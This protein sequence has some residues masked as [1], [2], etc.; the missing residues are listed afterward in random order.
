MCRLH[1]H[2]NASQQVLT[3]NA[4]LYVI[5][6]MLDAERKQLQHQSQQLYCVVIL[7]GRFVVYGIFQERCCEREGSLSLIL[8][9]RE[10]TNKNMNG[11]LVEKVKKVC[12]FRFISAGQHRFGIEKNSQN[13]RQLHR[14]TKFGL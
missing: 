5:A 11:I 1:E 7:V 4:V 12:L 9:K 8:K 2:E 3:Y 13:A 10:L 14:S 6:V